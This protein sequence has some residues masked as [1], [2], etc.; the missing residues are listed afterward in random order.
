MYEVFEEIENIQEV[1]KEVQ[2]KKML[3]K[4]SSTSLFLQCTL[5][6]SIVC[7]CCCF[8]FEWIRMSEKEWRGVRDNK[9]YNGQNENKWRKPTTRQQQQPPTTT[10]ELQ[11]HNGQNEKK[12]TEVN[13][14]T[15]NNNY[16]RTTTTHRWRR[17]YS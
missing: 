14:T 13:K 10:A 17:P 5:I 2:D 4:D 12:M 3:D 16:S 7:C 6:E 8:V 11:Q 15:T 9:N 1:L